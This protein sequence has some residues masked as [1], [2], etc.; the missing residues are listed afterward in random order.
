[1]KIDDGSITACLDGSWRSVVEIRSRLRLETSRISELASS[2]D[3]LAAAGQI[4]TSAR[5]TEAPRRR[6][7]KVRGNLAIHFYRR[8]PA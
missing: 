5:E 7:R 3:R 4:E 1:M 2:L 6:G 8:I